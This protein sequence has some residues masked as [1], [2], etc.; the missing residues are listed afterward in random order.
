[1]SGSTLLRFARASA[2]GVLAAA[3]LA[4]ACA[5]PLLRVREGDPST[6]PPWR[7]AVLPAQPPS[8]ETAKTNGSPARDTLEEARTC[9]AL[10][11]PEGPFEVIP[12]PL[13][14]RDQPPPL[15][16]HSSPDEV[17]AAARALHADLVLVPEV[18]AW[19]RR[20]Y[21]IHA[22]ARVGIQA[23]VYD[24]RTGALLFQSRQEQVKNEGIFKIPLGALPVV[25]GPI[26]G[27]QHT[28]L[29]YMCDETARRIGEDLL[30]AYGS[31]AGS[32]DL[33]SSA[34]P[35]AAGDRA[36]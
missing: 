35:L 33:G 22:V 26:L 19:H 4:A 20:Y 27:L 12:L 32:A 8:G 7:L 16:P 25:V 30:R 18:T 36:R 13:V 14:D 2:L 9:V 23:R 24:G 1:M 11:I 3:A 10:E 21:L 5:S 29:S 28:H 31:I 17:V 6:L 15:G 34:T